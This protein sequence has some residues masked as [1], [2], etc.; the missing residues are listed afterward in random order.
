[1]PDL[2]VSPPRTV[3]SRVTAILSTFRSGHR[4][5]VTEISRL[6]GLPVSTT[7]RLATELV[8]WQLLER[9]AEGR[10]GVGLTVQLLGRDAGAPA[11]TL[12][13][14][15][16]QVLTD[17]W[18]ATHRRARLGVLHEGRVAYVEKRCGAEPVSAFCTGAT[19]PAHATALGK[20]L[21]AFAPPGTVATV[22]QRLTTHTA[23]TLDTPDK[24]R[25]A[26][27]VVRLARVAVAQGELR[28]EEAGVAVPVFG[29]AGKVVAALELEVHDLP[30]DLPVVKAAL[31]VA[32][33]SLSRELAAGTPR[34]VHPAVRALHEAQAG[35]PA[36]AHRSAAGA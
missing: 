3:V 27:G 17:L 33:G 5:S 29:C 2:S 9:T 16:P 19:L 14:R 36:A 20:A 26:L 1:M 35:E 28:P 31:A 10:Y 13:E 7:H 12:H 8:S 24:L 30:A 15:A 34:S 4:R 23:R 32:A 11:P 18:E 25:R 22:A 21:L 6:T